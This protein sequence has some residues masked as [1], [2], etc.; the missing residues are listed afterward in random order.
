MPKLMPSNRK[1]TDN[2]CKVE[3]GWIEH[4]A[5]I[6]HGQTFLIKQA[7]LSCGKEMSRLD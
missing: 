5:D 1:S 6:R 2:A 4:Q 7:G 3:Y